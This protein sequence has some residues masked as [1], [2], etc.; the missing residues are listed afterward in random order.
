[1]VDEQKEELRRHG[2]FVV[3]AVIFLIAGRTIG[4]RLGVRRH[5]AGRLSVT[6]ARG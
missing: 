6:Q 1:M 4:P 3:P 5:A 2:C